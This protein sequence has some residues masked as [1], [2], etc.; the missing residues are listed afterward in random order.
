MENVRLTSLMLIR[1]NDGY[2][3]RATYQFEDERGIWEETY[4]RICLPI[5]T[6]SRPMINCQFGSSAC[7]NNITVDL[8][9]GELPLKEI[10]KNV[11]AERKLIKEKIHDMTISEIEEKLGYK[12]KIIGE[13]GEN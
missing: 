2:F 8:G 12:I 6:S 1:E 5:C 10:R 9:F 11:Y 13:K 4:P 3:L 7:A